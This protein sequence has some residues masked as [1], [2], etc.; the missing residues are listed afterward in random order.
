ML[1]DCLSM[2]L[3]SII[4]FSSRLV[5]NHFHPHPSTFKALLLLLFTQRKI[6]CM[7]PSDQ[8]HLLL[9]ISGFKLLSHKQQ[10]ISGNENE[11]SA[12]A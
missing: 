12:V 10:I 9:L 2:A 7:F 5:L 4:A 8:F 1:A 11:N 6:I 3:V